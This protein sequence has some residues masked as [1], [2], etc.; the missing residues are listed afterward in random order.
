MKIGLSLPLLIVS[1][2]APLGWSQTAT[3]SPAPAT[4][5]KPHGP[6]AIA[7]QDPN[8]VVATINGQKITAKQVVDMLKPFPADQR[9]QIDGNLSAAV[10]QI[11][12]QR[13][14]AEAAHQLGLEKQSPYKEQLELSQQSVLARAYITHLSDTATKE[15][16]EDPQKYYDAHKTEFDLAKLS[17]IFV[18]FNPPG[19]PAAGGAP[20]ARTEEQA[21]EKANDLEKKI[22]AGGDFAALARAESEH[23]TAA[24]GGDLGTVPINDPQVQIPA[25]VKAAVAKLQP[26]QVSEPV[27]VPGAFLIVKL[28]SREITS[29]DKA[30]AGIQQK[31]QGERS[32]TVVKKEVEKYTIHVDDPDFFDNGTA[33][34]PGP[35]IPSLQRPAAAPQPKP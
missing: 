20:N 18:G 5:A 7:A 22:A 30:K 12:T 9:K 35:K 19:T 17:G 16:A 32:Q 2:F 24:K 8:R 13:Q 14:L 4:V 25:E 27:R 15:P 33:A 10:Q 11:Y 26:G 21:R 31:L 23:Q 28:D 29:F 3:P 34:T 6:E 1:S